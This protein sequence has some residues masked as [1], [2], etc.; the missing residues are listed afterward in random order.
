M[1]AD[2]PAVRP[3]AHDVAS[4]MRD[5]IRSMIVETHVRK[6]R[7]PTWARVADRADATKQRLLVGGAGAL[8]GALAVGI[9]VVIWLT[10]AGLPA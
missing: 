5:I 8:L 1:T 9:A 7:V 10:T 6:G 3:N 2:D 4:T